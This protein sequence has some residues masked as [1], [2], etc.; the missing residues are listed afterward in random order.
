MLMLSQWFNPN[1]KN[2]T[3]VSDRRNLSI[4]CTTLWLGWRNDTPHD[5]TS[6]DHQEDERKYLVVWQR[7]RKEVSF[8]SGLIPRPLLLLYYYTTDIEYF[9]D[10]S[11]SPSDRIFDRIGQEG[12]ILCFYFSLMIEMDMIIISIHIYILL[13]WIIVNTIYLL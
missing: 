6:D 5:S 3:S 9:I 1:N 2:N 11:S 10:L 4:Y 7:K 8:P 12:Y 13:G